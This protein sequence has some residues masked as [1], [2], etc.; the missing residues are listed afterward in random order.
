VDWRVDQFSVLSRPY[1]L[2]VYSVGPGGLPYHAGS[3]LVV[4]RYLRDL[5]S[6]SARI[7]PSRS[8]PRVAAFS[9]AYRMAR[10]AGMDYFILLRTEETER[11]VLVL[12][13]LYVGRTGALVARLEVPRSGNDRIAGAAPGSC[14][15]S[16]PCFPCAVPSWSARVSR[17]W[18]ISAGLW[19]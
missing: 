9:D 8:T 1:S 16:H 11:D 3:D 17:P 15:R 4:A 14:M 10:E 12:A 13:E 6:S 2:A 5:L 7:A 18:S 19:V